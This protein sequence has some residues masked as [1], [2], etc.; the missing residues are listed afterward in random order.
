MTEQTPV[1]QLRLCVTAPD[2]ADALRFYRDV[3]GLAERGSYTSPAGG[4]VTILDAGTAT[5]ELADPE[6]AAYIDQVEVGSRVAGP[7][8]VAVEVDDCRAVTG[9]LAGA[10]AEVIAPPTGTPW[11]SLNARLSAPAGLQLTVF[12]EQAPRSAAPVTVI[13]PDRLTEADPTPGMR[14]QQA[15]GV[16]GLWSGLVHTEP[17]A[18][19]GWHHHGGHETSLYVVSGAMRLEFGGSVVDAGPG[20]FIHVPAHVVHRESNPTGHRATAVIARAGTGV[21]TVNVDGP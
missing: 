13:G 1:R 11:N 9:R 10:G 19:S 7:V 16:P 20:D 4:R 14:R 6:Y 2:Y 8:R 3:L 18:T 5:L 15:I 21:P 12:A 17:G